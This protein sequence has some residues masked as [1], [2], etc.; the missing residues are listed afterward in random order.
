MVLRVKGG[1]AVK[2]RNYEHPFIILQTTESLDLGKGG[3]VVTLVGYGSAMMERRKLKLTPLIMMGL[4]AEASK[5]LID[6]L[7]TLFK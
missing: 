1:L 4:N 5:M 3:I 6:E 7:N 2:K